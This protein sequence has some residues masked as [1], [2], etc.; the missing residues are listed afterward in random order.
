MI[1]LKKMSLSRLLD[2]WELTE[3]N[4]DKNIYDVRGWLMD[5]IK[6]RNPAGFA[7]WLDQEEPEDKQLRE[8][9]TR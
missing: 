3:T 6:S 2:L 8:F 7:A 9:V 4:N 5:E 1:N